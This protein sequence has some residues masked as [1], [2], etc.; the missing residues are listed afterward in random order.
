MSLEGHE[1]ARTRGKTI[2]GATVTD[3]PGSLVERASM[4]VVYVA[5]ADAAVLE[6][7]ARVLAT[8]DD[9]DVAD[10]AELVL[11]APNIA[12]TRPVRALAVIARRLFK[13]A[14][15][16]RVLTA[17]QRA[18]ADLIERTAAAI[19]GLH[20]HGCAW[21]RRRGRGRRLTPRRFAIELLAMAMSAGFS[22]DRR[23]AEDRPER[24]GPSGSPCGRS[25]RAA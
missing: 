23:T 3:A 8:T 10:A 24:S 16:D 14:S 6:N 5:A 2:G 15:T 22:E 11:D 21:V 20:I 7:L 13:L 1:S 4:R 19:D 12:T 17:D 18:L 25:G 9:S